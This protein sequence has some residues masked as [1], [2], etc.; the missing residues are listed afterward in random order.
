[1]YNLR[2]H[3]MFQSQLDEL[4]NIFEQINKF[5]SDIHRHVYLQ[6]HYVLSKKM[7][8]S[9]SNFIINLGQKASSRNRHI[10]L[11]VVWVL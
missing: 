7:L 10:L 6:T 4:R 8:A 1:M 5:C 2:R 3:W 11:E 9:S